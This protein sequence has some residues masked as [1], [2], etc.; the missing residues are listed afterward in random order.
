MVDHWH[1]GTARRDALPVD[2]GRSAVPVAGHERI[3]ARR[4]DRG[5]DRRRR[6]PRPPG[7]ALAGGAR[8]VTG[9][10]WGRASGTSDA[11]RA[12]SPGPRWTS[13]ARAT[14]ATSATSS[15]GT[16]AAAALDVWDALFAAGEQH[17]IRPADP[18]VDVVR[19]EAGLILIEVDYTSV[20]RATHGR[21]RVT[22]FE[23]GL[24]R[25]VNFER[26]EFV[27][28]AALARGFAEPGPRG[29]AG[30]A[31]ARLGRGSRRAFAADGLAPAVRRRSTASPRPRSSTPAAR[32]AGRRAPAGRR[33]SRR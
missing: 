30:R 13:A 29:G 2:G 4:R 33:R 24:G 20:M 26:R 5:R 6:R 16:P 32:S 28:K 31:R 9:E 22:P 10:E 17:G 25:L 23:I 3:R 1:G 21:A 18:R 15:A 11:G 7:A 8:G 27:G 12:P 19:V 14:P